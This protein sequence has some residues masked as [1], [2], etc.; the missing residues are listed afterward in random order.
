MLQTE[1][2]NARLEIAALREEL[3]EK[4][5]YVESFSALLLDKTVLDL[6]DGVKVRKVKKIYENIAGVE[7]PIYQGISFE[8]L[9]YSLF[10]TPPWLDSAIHYLKDMSEC[11]ERVYIIQEKK[12]AL[13]KE[14]REVS[15]RVNLFEKVLIPR[16]INNIKKIKVF[17][18]DQQ[19][20]AVAQA[21]VAK[22]KIGLR[23]IEKEKGDVL[24]ELT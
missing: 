18:G 23:K 24:C 19:L 12:E 14:L 6:T 9:K 4:R 1:V 11:R 21:K 10:E 5:K 16:S 3:E 2:N 15:I 8:E 22:T 17:L 20:S 7:I 13:E